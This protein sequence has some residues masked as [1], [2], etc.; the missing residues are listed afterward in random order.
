MKNSK[1]TAAKL[2][3]AGIIGGAVSLGGNIAYD[4]FTGKVPAPS[5]QTS[6][7]KVSNVSYK[8]SSGTTKAIAKVSDAVVSV[9][10]YQKTTA[11]SSSLDELFGNDSS[12]ASKDGAKEQPA[13]EGSGVIYKKDGDD[14]YVVTNNHVV[15][16]ASSLEILLSNGNKVKGT[17]VGKDVYSDLA[18]IKIPAKE[19]TKVAEFGD[20]A[21][22]TVGEPAI[23]IGSPLGS[24]YANSA[25]EG[26]ISSLSR[27]V[28]M[29]NESKETV[30]VNAIQT[31]AA[32]NPG[33]SGGALLNVE[34]QVIGINSS[35]ISATGSSSQDVSVEGMGFAIPSNDVV[36]IIDKLEK[37]GEIKR[38]ALGVQ[39]VDLTG[40]NSRYTEELKLPDDVTAGVVIAKVQKGL[41]ADT[42]GLKKYDVITKIGDTKVATSTELQSALY[43]YSIGDEMKV[44]YYREGKEKTATVKLAA[45]S[46]KL[47][48]KD[49][50]SAKAEQDK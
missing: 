43:K 46:D 3:A 16:G 9:I 35:K 2:I 29:Q 50:E 1:K 33:N 14:A 36:A 4:H 23:A 24:E 15:D 25:T 10:N 19:V 8:V 12:S 39:M 49:T 21:K 20:S 31:D 44:T 48:F 5:N 30:N 42:A 37:D 7:N 17:L 40:L 13:G 11:S 34:G 38:P 22:L 6:T 32:I 27:K 45:S 18:V 47:D 41:P 26:I 28:I